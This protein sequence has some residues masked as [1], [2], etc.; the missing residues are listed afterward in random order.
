MFLGKTDL[1]QLAS[2]FS[3]SLSSCAYSFGYAESL[4]PAK[5]QYRYQLSCSSYPSG[6]LNLHSE[7]HGILLW[8]NVKGRGIHIPVCGRAVRVPLSTRWDASIRRAKRTAPVNTARTYE[9]YTYSSHPVSKVSTIEPPQKIYSW[10]LAWH[11]RRA[12]S[13]TPSASLR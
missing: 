6:K 13:S 12:D 9:I 10:S 3:F 4:L 11:W 5:L 8:A 2:S 7:F 1:P